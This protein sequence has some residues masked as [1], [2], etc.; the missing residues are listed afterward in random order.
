MRARE[1]QIPDNEEPSVDFIR[2]LHLDDEEDFLALT[3]SYLT[4]LSQNIILDSVSRPQEALQ[5]LENQVYDVIISDYQMPDLTG[6]DLLS[7][8]RQANNSTPFIILTGKGREEV[9]IQALN[10]GADYYLQKGS[11]FDTL[12]AELNNIIQKETNKKRET[13]KRKQAVYALKRSYENLEQRVKEGTTEIL[14]VNE[15]LK[16]EIEKQERTQV[17]LK[18]SE[19]RFRTFFE[20]SPVS[21]WEEDFSEFKSYIDELRQSGVKNFRDYFETH[22]EAVAKCATMV[23]ILDINKAT[24]SLYKA[25]DKE[26]LLGNLDRIF[27]SE[28]YDSFREE[29][30]TLAEGKTE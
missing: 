12:S 29:I 10:L 13:E 17:A 21:L 25:R 23:K 7:K 30:I 16:R 5:C 2:V 3:K 4:K 27:C 18:K 24:L 20:E 11:D 1:N 26:E 15:Q 14:K 6:L 9:V 28:S 19:A 8:I 22:P